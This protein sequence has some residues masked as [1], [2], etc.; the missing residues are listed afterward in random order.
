MIELLSD[1]ARAATM[2]VEARA[3]VLAH[4]S[5]ASQAELLATLFRRAAARDEPAGVHASTCGAAQ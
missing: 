2:A 4:F 3:R 5:A 1:P